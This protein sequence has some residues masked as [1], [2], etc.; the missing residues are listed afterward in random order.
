MALALILFG[1]LTIR[2]ERNKGLI[3]LVGT[4]LTCGKGSECLS[5][6]VNRVIYKSKDGKKEKIFD[7]LE[8]AQRALTPKLIHPPYQATCPPQ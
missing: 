4:S 6:V 7:A 2:V 5:I 8:N 1:F 3:N